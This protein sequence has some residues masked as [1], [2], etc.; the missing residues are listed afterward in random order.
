MTMSDF[1]MPNLPSNVTIHG[2][3]Y[4]RIGPLKEGESPMQGAA[5]WYIYDHAPRMDAAE[6]QG[7]DSQVVLQLETFLHDNNQVTAL[8]SIRHQPDSVAAVCKADAATKQA[9]GRH[10]RRAASVLKVRS[11]K[12]RRSNLVF[13]FARTRRLSETAPSVLSLEGQRPRYHCRC[14]H[15]CD[16]CHCGRCCDVC[17]CCHCCRCQC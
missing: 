2:K 10:I 5:N 14:G 7:L 3:P 1:H 15:C 11:V 12:R 16:S 17:F 4:H 6:K 9:G 8:P 13:R